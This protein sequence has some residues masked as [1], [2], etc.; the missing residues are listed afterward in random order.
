AIAVAGDAASSLGALSRPNWRFVGMGSSR[1]AALDA[2]VRLRAAGLDAHAETASASL[3]A[4]GGRDTVIV[5]I[6]ASG[7]T[8]EV[9][10]AVERHHGTS[11]VLGL[12]ARADSPLARYSDAVVPL[13]AAVVESG[14]VASLTYRATVAALIGLVGMGEPDE[15]RRALVSAGPALAE[16]IDG[17]GSWLTRA[18]DI[19]DGARD[20]HVL[21][22]GAWIGGCEQAALMLREAPRLPAIAFDTGD[23]LHVGLYTLF[24][25]DPVLLS[26]GSAADGEALRTIRDRGG[27]AVVVG[28]PTSPDLKRAEGEV[29]IPLPETA[30]G[31]R[32]I[33]SIV[34]SA[35]A[36]LLAAELW[37]RTSARL[38]GEAPAGD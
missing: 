33:R 1:F 31:N 8:P 36:E 32:L 19:L 20:V 27:R 14:G 6:S 24:P 26:T 10:D 3:H 28:T 15:T 34:E 16:L 4:P 5:A 37:G 38:V 22:N 2:A 12:T 13:A 35:V 9:L 17:R 30:V 29:W 7:R 18:A 11:F 25:G 23:W 21:G